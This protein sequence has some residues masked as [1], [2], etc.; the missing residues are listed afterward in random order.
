MNTEIKTIT[1]NGVE[2]VERSNAPVPMGDKRIIV[3]DRGWVFVGSCID[4]A[5][6]SV[7]IND[8][9]CIR[10]WGTTAGL[11]QLANGPTDK[12]KHDAY[13][14]VRCTPIVSIAVVKGW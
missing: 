14:T 5:D 1:I 7:T 3:T 11:G 13:G 8:A 2:Y 12:T 4:N 6:G 10:Y 9:R